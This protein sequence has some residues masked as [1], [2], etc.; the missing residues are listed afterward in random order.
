MMPLLV[1]FENL[2]SLSVHGNRLKSLPA[3]MSK[4]QSL[5]E[6]D[7]SNNLF[8]DIHAVISSLKTIPHLAHLLYSFKNE[9]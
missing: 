3:D 6:L 1:K 8:S 2:E 9:G 7:I 4:L 5:I